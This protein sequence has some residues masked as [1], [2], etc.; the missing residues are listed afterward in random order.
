MQNPE[1]QEQVEDA[2]QALSKLK[3]NKGVDGG[4]TD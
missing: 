4:K 3:E 1:L 2:E